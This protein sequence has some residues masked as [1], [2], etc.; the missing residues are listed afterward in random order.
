MQLV[1]RAGV[2]VLEAGC[3]PSLEGRHVFQMLFHRKEA[4]RALGALKIV[5]CWQGRDLQ[6]NLSHM[7]S[8][9]GRSKVEAHGHGQGAVMMFRSRRCGGVVPVAVRRGKRGEEL[10]SIQECRTLMQVESLPPE[11]LEDH[12]HNRIAMSNHPMGALLIAGNMQLGP[13]LIGRLHTITCTDA[14][15]S[16]TYGQLSKSQRGQAWRAWYGC[17]V[18]LVSV[19]SYMSNTSLTPLQWLEGLPRDVQISKCFR[20]APQWGFMRLQDL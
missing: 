1:R 11:E 7:A 15:C 12:V 8:P 10:P 20:R 3:E 18:C 14:S 16:L 5:V 2:H 13:S 19:A 17:E 9:Y 6:K 4:Q